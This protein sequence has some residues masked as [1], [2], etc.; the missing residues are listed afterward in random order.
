MKVTILHL[1]HSWTLYELTNQ[2]SKI[3]LLLQSGCCWNISSYNGIGSLIVRFRI[4]CMLRVGN[5]LNYSLMYWINLSYGE[6][7]SWY[8]GWSY[9]RG[10]KFKSHASC[11]C[12]T[13]LL[14]VNPPSGSSL[15]HATVGVFYCTSMP[16]NELKFVEWWSGLKLDLTGY[17]QYSEQVMI[18]MYWRFN[19]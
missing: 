17:V 12:K 7:E 14:T 19:S 4:I 5:I 10:Q 13:M 1:N 2:C 6:G 8:E 18:L 3:K 15:N 11:K 9:C 16:F